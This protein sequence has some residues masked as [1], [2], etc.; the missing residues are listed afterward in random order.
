MSAISGLNPKTVNFLSFLGRF[1]GGLNLLA[2][3]IAAM[4]LVYIVLKKPDGLEPDRN[5]K[6]KKYAVLVVSLAVLMLI[7]MTNIGMMLFTDRDLAV[8]I[9]LLALAKLLV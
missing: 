9:G 8:M 1:S 4:W 7:T 3:G 2:V 5:K 6:I